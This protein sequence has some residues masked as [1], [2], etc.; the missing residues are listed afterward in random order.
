MAAKSAKLAATTPA[1]ESDQY[2]VIARRYRPQSFPDLVGQAHV[3]AA[4][5]NAIQQNR[6]GHA[7]LFSGA[8]G[9]GKTSSARILAKCLNCQPGPTVTPCQV[10]DS[11]QG[12]TSGDDLDVLEIDGAS[13]RRIEEIRQL[14]SNVNI[15]PSRSRY[16]IY[17]IDE[18]HMLTKEAFNALLK[19]L[20]EPPEHV[21]F[22]FCTTELDKIPITIRS[23]C[24]L[25]EFMPVEERA[26]RQRLKQIAQAE[27][28]DVDDE[29]LILLSRRAA[30]SMRD[31]QSLLEQLLSLGQTN[32]TLSDV[33]RFLGTA[34]AQV[35]QQI[36]EQLAA[37]NSA[38]AMAAAQQAFR[39]GVD[40][41][42]LATQLLGYFRDCLAASIGCDDELLLHASPDQFAFV[43]EL[44]TQMGLE[45]ALAIA[46]I[47]DD[48]LVKMRYS[49]HPQ[50][51]LELS[52]VRIGRLEQL[53]AISDLIE[54]LRQTGPTG[55]ANP[56]ISRPPAP[57]RSPTAPSPRISG[58]APSAASSSSQVAP[59]KKNE[60]TESSTAYDSE[61]SRPQ[62][63]AK[64]SVP[65][66]AAES[67]V[68]ASAEQSAVADAPVAM[69]PA[70]VES[71]WKRAIG[72]L[73]N[74]TADMAGQY[75][76]LEWMPDGRIV[77]TLSEQFQRYCSLPERK[78]SV[79]CMLAQVAGQAVRVDF[80]AAAT[81]VPPQVLAAPISRLKLM[82]D[83]ARDPL[84]RAAI[85]LF[86]A[87]VTDASGSPTT[88]GEPR[89]PNGP[90]DVT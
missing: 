23:R 46:Q 38:G 88:L 64:P 80:R 68:P 55:A 51:L 4:L 72:L 47:L 59:S 82:R 14:R 9:T 83:S 69:T 87:T 3:A 77:V 19:T 30:G 32:I 12:I 27:H 24:Q 56:A 89:P 28:V 18:V 39:Q 41:G 37:R 50:V 61:E 16:K 22:I 76:R 25:F 73:G 67:C 2:L 40:A 60:P 10:C 70:N 13:N 78:S 43:R 29:A 66:T 84:V 81:A 57:A 62:R 8:R 33:N 53:Q 35:V 1:P 15:R 42:Q 63:A 21:K 54:Q 5:S 34:D 6:V 90:H 58:G 11:C 48:C 65:S 49:T 31:S 7:Y 85:D 20:E 36:V 45:Q 44:G 74:T 52:L 86:D 17:I 26:I 71:I 79:E 75:Q